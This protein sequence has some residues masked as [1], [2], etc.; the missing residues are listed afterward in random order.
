MPYV[1]CIVMESLRMFGGRALTVPHRALRDTQLLG[2]TIPKDVLVIGN[3][4]GCML[5]DGGSFEDPLL[6]KPER[7]MKN[8]RISIPDDFIPFGMGKHRCLGESL[9]R[10]SVFLFIA[11]L[12]Q[13]FTFSVVPEH[14]P[15]TDWNDGITPGPKQFKARVK[16]RM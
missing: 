9:A 7:F 5:E 8:G 3:L 16:P 11:T 10:A 4:Y 1:E 15:T 2:Y 12:L 14:P 6:F 13:N